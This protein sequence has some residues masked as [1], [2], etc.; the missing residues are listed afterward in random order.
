[1]PFELGTIP[2][3]GSGEAD[4]FAFEGHEAVLG[5]HGLQVL[6]KAGLPV[7]LRHC[8]QEQLINDVPK[9]N[10][11]G[12]CS[13]IIYNIELEAEVDIADCKC[14]IATWKAQQ[15][16]FKQYDSFESA[17]ACKNDSVHL[18]QCQ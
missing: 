3:D 5:E 12:T 14:N 13:E 2:K 8:T 18:L 10:P 15:K 6:H 9:S 16:M 4:H 17:R 11:N 7:V 1:M